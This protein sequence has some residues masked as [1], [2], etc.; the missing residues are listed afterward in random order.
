M[1]ETLTDEQIIENAK[2]PLADLF[3][4]FHKRARMKGFHKLTD[5]IHANAD[6]TEV[7]DPELAEYMRSVHRGNRLMLIAGE[8]VEAHDEIRAGRLPSEIYYSVTSEVGYPKPEGYLSE[9][10]D[11][12]VRIGD[13][14]GEEDLVEEFMDIMEIKL[15]FNSKRPEKNG[16]AF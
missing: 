2:K 11:A 12:F 4:L 16:K 14:I 13:T 5:A 15:N 1:T 6:I 8:L 3:R 9:M 7:S 10:F